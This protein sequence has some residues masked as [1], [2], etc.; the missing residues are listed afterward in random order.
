MC[1]ILKKI[2]SSIMLIL[3]ILA[4]VQKNSDSMDYRN[5]EPSRM[6]IFISG[7]TYIFGSKVIYTTNYIT[8]KRK[9]S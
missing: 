6:N 3:F 1:N 9:N 8:I 4:S 5:K 2:L 7:E